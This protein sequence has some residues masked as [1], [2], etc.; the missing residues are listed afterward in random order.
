VPA[1]DRP[2]T[3]WITSSEAA[4]DLVGSAPPGGYTLALVDHEGSRVL[5]VYGA[6]AQELSYAAYALLEELGARF[7]HPMQDLVPD[8][9]APHL[10][11]TL[12]LRREPAFATRGLVQRLA[13]AVRELGEVDAVLVRACK[14]PDETVGAWCRELVDGAAITRLRLDHSRAL[15]AAVIAAARGGD[16][17]DGLDEAGAI[18]ER[19]AA[20]VQRRASDYRFDA[21]RLVESW[22]NPTAYDFGY[23]RQAHTLCYWHR[24]GRAGRERGQRRRR[25]GARVA[26]DLPRLTPGCRAYLVRS[27]LSAPAQAMTCSNSVLTDF[28][29]FGSGLN[30]V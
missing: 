5:V 22:E 3:I 8:L 29:C 4:R 27:V 6:G 1:F 10:P 20:V 18:R 15:Y 26:A 19:A 9:G 2:H 30:L 13:E 7:F 14:R 16:A 21:A 28:S 12:D 23:L 11:A 24:P 25:R 17:S